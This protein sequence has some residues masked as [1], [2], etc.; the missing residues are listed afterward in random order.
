MDIS[1]FQ[2]ESRRG[3]KRGNGAAGRMG[4]DCKLLGEQSWVGTPV[5][6][7]SLSFLSQFAVPLCASLPNGM[8]DTHRLSAKSGREGVHKASRAALS[9]ELKG[10]AWFTWSNHSIL[11]RRKS[12][13]ERQK[14]LSKVT[15]LA[16]DRANSVLPS[17]T[18]LLPPCPADIFLSLLSVVLV[19][20]PL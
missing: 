19:R 20:V 15:P 1:A 7:R 4:N 11:Q 14:D 10:T 9:L 6:P 16:G 12:S 2:K 13:S 17:R 5:R 3:G 8:V 18:V